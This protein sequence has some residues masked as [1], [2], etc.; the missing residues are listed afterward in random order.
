MRLLY[1]KIPMD[2]IS[3]ISF[4]S[5]H[6]KQLVNGQLFIFFSQRRLAALVIFADFFHPYEQNRSVLFPLSYIP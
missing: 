5:M 2:L 1:P 3:G 6:L 4:P